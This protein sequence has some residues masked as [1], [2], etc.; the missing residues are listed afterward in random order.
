M[1]AAAAAA[2]LLAYL[3][4]AF[5][6]RGHVRAE[7]VCAHVPDRPNTAEIFNSVLPQAAK[8]SFDGTWRPD[9]D[10]Q[11]RS[12]C[13]VTGVDDESLFILA[14]EMGS[15]RPW[16]R[17]AETEIP[18]N[19][20]GKRTYFNA[21]LKGVSNSEVAAI[22][23]PC[24]ANEKV[25]NQPWNMTVLADALRPLKTSDKKARQILIDLAIDFARQAH[26][27]AK[28]D[29]PSKLPS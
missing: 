11:F 17:W 7:D 25:N 10:W 12:A 9:R 16:Q 14:A 29:L 3:L 5:E 8:Y 23:V 22:W 27:D 28:C 21:G 4:G 15:A 13:T 18:P 6:K 2:L 1:A 20:G 26:R 19:S 24:Y